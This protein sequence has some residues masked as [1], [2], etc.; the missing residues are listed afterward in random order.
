MSLTS[1]QK[2]LG[3]SRA[4][5]AWGVG[6]SCLAA[7]AFTWV[8]TEYDFLTPYE[9]MLGPSYVVISF[10]F[11][12]AFMMVSEPSLI[13]VATAFKVFAG[14][15]ALGGLVEGALT[16]NSNV[17][18][19]LAWVPIY[20]VALIFGATIPSQRRWGGIFFA[21]S[22]V[23][24]LLGLAFGPVQFNDPHAI[25]LIT[26]LLGQLSL[27]IVFSA[28]AKNLHAGA[29]ADTE[30]KALEG[31]AR[32]LEFAAEKAQQA[33]VAKSTFIANMSH[34]FRTPLNAITGFAQVIKGE[35]GVQLADDKKREYAA[36]I[37]K[38]ADHLLSLINDILDLSKI[39]A[40][41]MELAKEPINIKAVFEEMQT[42][43]LSL[44]A[45]KSIKLV[46]DVVGD[47][48]NLVADARSIR[49]MLLNLLSNAIKF[50]EEGGTIVMLATKSPSGGVEVSLSDTGIGMGEKTLQRVLAPFEQAEKAYLK[51][52]G[53]TGLGLPLVQSLARLLGA[54]FYIQS[55]LGSGTDAKLIFPPE[56]TTTD[57][58]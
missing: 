48:P 44:L 15:V 6:L 45:G 7:A 42:M 1:A 55:R 40:G 43:A 13:A 14:L 29:L 51:Q 50:T 33:N 57:S 28:L 27:L 49:Q 31:H 8:G 32:M 16:Y 23:S 34:E 25:L 11:V 5:A 3:I 38:S 9:Q 37:E 19:Y 4:G 46:I 54:E 26:A 22:S 17:E 30:L 35:A 20:Y 53:G 24:V 56:S 52:E 47:V 39:E 18:F 12:V 2:L 36:D 21:T 10:A 41:K 58:A